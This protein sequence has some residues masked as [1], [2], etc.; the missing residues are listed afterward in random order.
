M[1]LA[2]P[3]AL[4][5]VLVLAFSL[6][7]HL[8]A[9]RSLWL[10]EAYS[11]EVAHRN[12][13][14]IWVFLR[15]NDAH[16]IGYYALLSTWIR[17]FGTDLT[18][19]RSL[20][21]IFGMGAVVLTW[22]LGRVL[23][24]PAVG[25]VAAALVSVNPFQIIASNELRMYPML[26]CLSLIS[27]WL[28]WRACASPP[29]A[30]WWVAYGV[31]AAL[32]GYTSYYA[33]FLFPAQA[34]WVVVWARPSVRAVTGLAVATATALVLYIPWIPY[35]LTLP[36]RFPWGWRAPI[37]LYYL[38]D[39]FTTQTFGG[40]LFSTAT[41]QEFGKL[42]FKYQPV[43]LFPLLVFLGAGI[44][45]L[46]RISRPARSLTVLLWVGSLVLIVLV[47]LAIG[48]MAAFTRHLVFLQPFAAL[49]LAGGIVYLRDALVAAPRGLVPLL[50]LLMVLSF[51]YPAVDNAQENPQYRYFSYDRAAGL[52]KRLYQ[53]GDTILYFPDGTAP[54][55]RYYFDPRGTQLALAVPH[56]RF[57]QAATEPAIGQAAEYLAAHQSN[58]VWLV[59]SQ[60]W[61]GDS[62]NALRRALFEK[63]FREGPVE[64]FHGVY[65]ELLVRPPAQP[66]R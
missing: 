1:T 9:T 4:L 49:L 56:R 37:G 7:W 24:S 5:G 22:L 48:R 23:F 15:G 13:H 66:P 61:P 30:G 52:V 42:A 19:M 3:L 6:R 43:L 59:F 45:A 47:S 32:A 29:R 34:L 65:V 63:H 58:R 62:V 20:S 16:P 55:F 40:Y 35:V 21:L 17:W 28:L 25:I 36:A 12:I 64:D 8:I 57:T 50:G 27:T 10:D 46:G 41:Y 38:S 11:L 31:S 26:T 33:F 18:A 44:F 39:L 14:N 53:P 51:A 60:P 2:E 54:A